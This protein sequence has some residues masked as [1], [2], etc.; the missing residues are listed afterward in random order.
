MTSSHDINP[1]LP[2]YLVPHSQE[3]IRIL[4]ADDS[5]LIID[6]PH[7]LLS[8]PGR[9]PLN[10][11]CLI[12][13][14]ERRYPGVAAAHR[15]DLD[16]SGIL[17]VPR[18]KTA[19]IALNKQFQ[20]RAVLKTYRALVYGSV[21]DDAGQIDLPLIRDWHNRPKQKIC[22]DTGKPSLTHYRVLD[23]RSNGSLLELKP[24]TGRSH[25]LRIHLMALGHPIMGCDLYA[26]QEALLAA[27]RL[28]LHACHLTFRHPITHGLLSAYSPAPFDVNGLLPL[29]PG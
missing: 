11:D 16:T 9:H 28:L 7:L 18:N 14:L 29:R 15:L 8:V 24:I 23:R 4:Y 21:K 19:L 20:D 5:L 12:S 6:K 3:N 22:N 17:V 25:Q 10:R 27:P 2:P 1:D 26:H 13:R